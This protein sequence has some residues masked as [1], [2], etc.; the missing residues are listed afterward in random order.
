[1]RIRVCSPVVE[2]ILLS[3]V[4]ANKRNDTQQTVGSSESQ[5]R[6]SP[7]TGVGCF[8]R[9]L[10]NFVFLVISITVYR[11]QNERLVVRSEIRFRRVQECREITSINAMVAMYP[12]EIRQKS[13]GPV[14]DPVYA[15]IVADSHTNR[16]MAG[17]GDFTVRMFYEREFA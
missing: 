14:C 16:F 11:R 10:L 9:A 5:E 2:L 3:Y 1:M 15:K 8:G 17:K 6:T 7:V 12:M 13:P 4:F